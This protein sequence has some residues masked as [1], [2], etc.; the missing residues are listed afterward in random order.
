MNR[1]DNYAIDRKSYRT[2]GEITVSLEHAQDGPVVRMFN[3]GPNIPEDKEVAL[4]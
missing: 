2:G 4:G 3:Y 1:D